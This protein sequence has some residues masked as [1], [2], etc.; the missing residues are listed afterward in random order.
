MALPFSR[1]S[2]ISSDAMS[3]ICDARNEFIIVRVV[4]EKIK[5]HV[6]DAVKIKV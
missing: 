6:F 2:R 1:A 5:T 4:N 3:L